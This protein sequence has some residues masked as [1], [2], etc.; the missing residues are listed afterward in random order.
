M[1]DTAM[2]TQEVDTQPLVEEEEGRG[3][4]I[5]L[6]INAFAADQQ[7]QAT[8]PA[9]GADSLSFMNVSGGDLNE[10]PEGEST[11]TAATPAGLWAKVMSGVES[12]KVMRQSVTADMAPW[13][14]F[15]DRSKFS[16]PSKSEV[17]GRVRGNLKIYHSN[18]MMLLAL[19]AVW[20]A[21]SNLYFVCSMITSFLMYYYY[22]MQTHE[23]GKFFFRGKEVSSM[24]FYGFLAAFT[25]FMFWLTGGGSTIFWMVASAGIVVIGHASARQV[26]AVEDSQYTAGDALK[27]FSALEALNRV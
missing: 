21:I 25:L 7:P 19:L 2:A 17:F 14:Q 9:T 20:T 3:E 8:A 23:G 12:V 10:Q 4:D 27:A 15:A 6:D 11:T 13:S 1:S 24:Q 22:R 26:E 16:V 18:Y 5:D